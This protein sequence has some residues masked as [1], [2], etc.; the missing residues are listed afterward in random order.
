MQSTP[1]R[2]H[3]GSDGLTRE[4]NGYGGGSP[5]SSDFRVYISACIGPAIYLAAG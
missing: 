2:R 4:Q 5:V 1:A 3:S